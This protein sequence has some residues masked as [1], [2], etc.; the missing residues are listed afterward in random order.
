MS[1]PPVHRT[2]HPPARH[3]LPIGLRPLRWQRR[4]VHATTAAL[5]LTGLAWLVAHHALRTTGTFGEQ[6]PSPLEP[7]ALRLH[8]V[9][10]QVFLLVLGSMTAVHIVLGWR[11]R[12]GRWSGGGLLAA[13]AV[14]FATGLALYYAPEGWHAGASLLHW[15]LGLALPLLLGLHVA[16]ARRA[17]RRPAGRLSGA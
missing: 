10:A 3:H 2:A 14:L 9:L 15:G 1:A 5:A 6:L 16:R 13:C 4:A 11:L 8:G 17:R 12:R 7:W